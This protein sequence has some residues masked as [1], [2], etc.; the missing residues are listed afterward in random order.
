MKT[1]KFVL[2]LAAMLIAAISVDAQKKGEKTVVFNA[3]LH[4]ASCKAK[5]EKNIPFEK[6]VKDLKVNMEAQTITIIFKEDKNTVENLQKAIEKLSVQIKGIAGANQ[7]VKG[8]KCC[9]VDHSK[10][11]KGSDQKSV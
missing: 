2:I 10:K 1:V 11:E 9:D 7:P 3:N 6:G 8:G 4:C 5:V